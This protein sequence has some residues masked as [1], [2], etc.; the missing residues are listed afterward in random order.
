ME[1][2]NTVRLAYRG[3]PNNRNRHQKTGRVIPRDH[4]NHPHPATTY[5]YE[6]HRQPAN[7]QQRF[8]EDVQQLQSRCEEREKSTKRRLDGDDQDDVMANSNKCTF[9][10]DTFLL[11]MLAARRTDE[12]PEKIKETKLP[13]RAVF[14]HRCQRDDS[15]SPL[16]L[17]AMILFF[18]V[19]H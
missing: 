17:L 7:Q 1:S 2:R 16:E 12:C 13:L 11:F 3:K 10:C 15:P 19:A 9:L 14:A 5:P 6:R 8:I 4:K 18:V